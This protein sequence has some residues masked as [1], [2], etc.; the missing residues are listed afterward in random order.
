MSKVS[1][2][3]TSWPEVMSVEVKTPGGTR[4]YEILSIRYI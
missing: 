1:K 3:N 4:S 2:S